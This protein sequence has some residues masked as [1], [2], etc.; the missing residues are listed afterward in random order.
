MARFKPPK[1]YVIDNSVIL[2]SIIAEEGSEMA[3][4][5]IL[6]KDLFEIS[7]LV[8]DIFRHE[9]FNKLI[10]AMTSEEAMEI[11]QE[12][13]SRQVSIIA[14]EDDL[15][16]IA[17]VLVKKYPKISF[18][19]AAYHALAKAYKA[20]LITADKKYYELTKKEGDVKLLEDLKL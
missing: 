1:V 17:N 2:K 5:L 20:E 10:K 7:I 6:L 3:R 11:F 13:I 9:F 18:Y 12:F 8:P 19:D 16:E 4:K 15:I 14:M